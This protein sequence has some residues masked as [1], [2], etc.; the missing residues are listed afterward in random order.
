MYARLFSSDPPGDAFDRSEARVPLIKTPSMSRTVVNNS[1]GGE[2]KDR[3]L[4][5]KPRY[6][7]LSE[8]F[9]LKH[10]AVNGSLRVSDVEE[11]VARLW[12]PPLHIYETEPPGN[13]K[14]LLVSVHVNG[15][16][17]DDL[18]EEQCPVRGPLG[19]P[20]HRLKHSPHLARKKIR[21][22]NQHSGAK[23]ATATLHKATGYPVSVN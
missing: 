20:L 4:K 13:D 23:T 11:S 8:Q 5:A 19:A 22:K 18:Q 7:W 17:S 12:P 3:H 16:R 14:N 10:R 9:Y 2:R 6:C 15:P 1:L 21:W